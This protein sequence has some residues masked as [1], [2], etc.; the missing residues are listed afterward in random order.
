VLFWPEPAG[1][2]VRVPGADKVVHAVLFGLLALTA[3][4]RF[5]GR[6]AVLGAVLGYAVVS[7]VAQALLLA[8][9]SGDAWDVVADVGGALCGW[10]LARRLRA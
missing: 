2:D 1:G 8:Q 3:R 10:W 5:G 7:E 4:A 9:R 6:L